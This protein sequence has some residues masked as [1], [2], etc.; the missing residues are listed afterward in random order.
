M[1]YVAD[2]E[3]NHDLD[4]VLADVLDDLSA[5]RAEGHQVLVHCHGGAS[6][7]GLVLRGWL[8]REKRMSVDEATAHVAERW[9][10]LGL[11][12]ASFTAALERLAAR[13][14]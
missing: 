11:W 8:V 6:R 4:A 10:H 7:T 13:V 1:A 12:N 3:W 14:R 9:P 2:N 5:L